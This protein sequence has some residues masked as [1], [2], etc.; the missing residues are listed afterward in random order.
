[1]LFRAAKPA[2]L[3]LK[4]QTTATTPAVKMSSEGVKRSFDSGL[5]LETSTGFKG[6]RLRVRF[7]NSL[8]YPAV[9]VMQR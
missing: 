6:A 9:R 5:F 1:M 3:K 4:N 2:G 8:K 7:P